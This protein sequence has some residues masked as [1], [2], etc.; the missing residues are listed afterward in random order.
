M[1]ALRGIPK[2]SLNNIRGIGVGDRNI[3]RRCN[4]ESYGKGRAVKETKVVCVWTVW[5]SGSGS[6]RG[7]FC[8]G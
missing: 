2:A 5:V 6:M 7:F 3:E 8:F 1:V 4:A